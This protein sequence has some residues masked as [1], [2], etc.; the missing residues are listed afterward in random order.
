MKVFSMNESDTMVAK[1]EEEAI[2]YMDET[3]GSGEWK[4]EDS[5]MEEVTDL[6]NNFCYFGDYEEEAMYDREN[7]QKYKMSYKELI[8]K[9]SDE[10]P[11]FFTTEI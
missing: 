1:S 10:C 11:L 4:D 8:E 5:P 7:M 9:H 3:Y 2:T 6:E